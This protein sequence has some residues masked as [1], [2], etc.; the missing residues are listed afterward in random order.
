MWLHTVWFEFFM[1]AFLITVTFFLLYKQIQSK[2][3]HYSNCRI[4]IQFIQKTQLSDLFLMWFSLCVVLITARIKLSFVTFLKVGKSNKQSPG[5]HCGRFCFHCPGALGAGRAGASPCPW[6]RRRAAQHGGS[7]L[8]GGPRRGEAIGW[9][10]PSRRSECCRSRVAEPGEPLR[11]GGE[12]DGYMGKRGAGTG[13]SRAGK[14]VHCPHPP[15]VPLN[16]M[17]RSSAPSPALGRHWTIAWFPEALRN[18]GTIPYKG[19]LD[20]ENGGGELQRA[21]CYSRV[22]TDPSCSLDLRN[23]L[24]FSFFFFLYFLPYVNCCLRR[25]I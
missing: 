19:L 3:K 15:P 22:D 2:W 1:T 14:A 5:L 13:E 23:P 16:G 4:N 7:R 18:G 10:V 20:S 12:R 8:A 11:D 24:L 6:Q 9:E 21:T 25:C 17:L